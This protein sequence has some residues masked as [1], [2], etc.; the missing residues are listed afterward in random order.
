[1]YNVQN[2]FCQEHQLELYLISRAVRGTAAFTAQVQDVRITRP[3]LLYM[4]CTSRTEQVNG[5]KSYPSRAQRYNARMT[6]VYDTDYVGSN[7][8]LR[9]ACFLRCLRMTRSERALLAVHID[10][11]AFK[12]GRRAVYNFCD[13]RLPGRRNQIERPIRHDRQAEAIQ[14]VEAEEVLQTGVD[15]DAAGGDF[16]YHAW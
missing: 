16:G 8:E 4:A 6:Q 13:Q 10:L 12:N 3:A 14:P 1:M 11:N 5:H 7:A 15:V 2:L 9:A